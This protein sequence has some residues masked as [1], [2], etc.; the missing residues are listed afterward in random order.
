MRPYSGI[1]STRNTSQAT[2]KDSRINERIGELEQTLNKLKNPTLTHLDESR[3]KIAF[4]FVRWYF[5]FISLIIIGAPVY[6]YIAGHPDTL[7]VSKLLNQIAT[8]LGTPL[9]FVVGYYFKEKSK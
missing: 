5:I 8:L 9:G 7:D 6:N 1:T 3:S 4:S 2:E